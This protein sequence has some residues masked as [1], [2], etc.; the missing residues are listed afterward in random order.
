MNNLVLLRKIS[1]YVLRSVIKGGKSD[2]D[3]AVIFIFN[4]QIKKGE[5]QEL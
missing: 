3:V 1:E 5:N 4:T 2:E